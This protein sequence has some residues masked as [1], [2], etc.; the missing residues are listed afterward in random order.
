LTGP[1]IAF[2]RIVYPLPVLWAYAA[3]DG[4]PGHGAIDPHLLLVFGIAVPLEIIAL[5]LYIRALKISP[6][7]L[8]VPFLSLTPA[9]LL[10]TSP[11]IMGEKTGTAGAVGVL[12][13]TFGAYVLFMNGEKSG[14][15]APFRQMFREKGALM[16]IIVAFIYSITSNFGK[17]GVLY[18]SPSFFAASY[19]SALAMVIFSMNARRGFIAMVAKKELIFIGLASALMIT[20]HMLAIR[21]V[22]VP[23]MISLKRSS[24]LISIILGGILFHEKGMAHKLAG[25]VIMMIGIL[26]VA[27]L[28]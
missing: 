13:I 9:F 21:L 2:G 5:M 19:Y 10:V 27:I 28:G 18:S 6:L 25:G 3:I 4:I 8:T 23:Y 26:L 17:M 16:M 1:S 14:P 24:L 12:C 22:V 20:F 7:S 15:L 11:V